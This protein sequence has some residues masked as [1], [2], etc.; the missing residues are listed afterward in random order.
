MKC[1]L[2]PWFGATQ[3]NIQKYIGLYNSLGYKV[4][5]FNYSYLDAI[6]Y[7]GWKKLRNE[8][9]ASQ[10]YDTVHAFSG[11]TLVLYNI[12][13]DYEKGSKFTFD[14]YIV[15]SGPIWPTPY[16][17]TNFILTNLKDKNKIDI[18]NIGRPV[19][20]TGVEKYWN[21]E[22]YNWELGEDKFNKWIFNLP[23]EN[24]LCLLGNN[25]DYIYQ[26]KITN[27]I[28]EANIDNVVFDSSHV[29][30]YQKHKEHYTQ[31][32]QDFSQ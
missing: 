10:H 31:V 28:S 16:E 30:A 5:V 23:C 21:Y 1:L 2:I 18:R 24:K 15:D 7:S 8:Q 32:I 29:N 9:M 14:K 6:T 22:G 27:W 17:T 19:L 26:D 12:S 11:G 13:G 20:E 3:K 25:D 4:D